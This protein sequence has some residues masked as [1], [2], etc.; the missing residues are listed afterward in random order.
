M[1]VHIHSDDLFSQKFYW[2]NKLSGELPETN[3]MLDYIRPLFSSHQSKSL[4]FDL[5]NDLSQQIINIANN[6]YFS[7]YLIIVSALNILLQRYTRNNDVIVGI[8]VYDQIGI[9]SVNS[10]VIALRNQVK[11]GISFKDLLLE[12]K[13][14]TIAAYTHQNYD[15]DE[16]I[17]I[18]E[19]P[20]SPSRCPIFDIV[21]LLENIHSKNNLEQLKNDITIAFLVDG[22]S[23]SINIEYKENLFKHENIKL[24]SR[25]YT[26]ILDNI[27]KDCNI[28]ISDLL[29]LQKN[30]E[31]QL[32]KDF[33][34]NTQ[35]Y[36]VNQTINQL[37][38]KQV[39]QTPNNIAVIHQETKLTYR[40][41]NQKA[42]QLA[43]L[44]RKLGVAKREFVGIFKDRDINFLI[45]ILAI[46][47]AGGAYVPI[48]ST[49]PPNRI[50]YMLS[51]S[52]VR[53]LLTDYPLLNNLSGLVGDCSQLSSI[54]CLDNVTT[55]NM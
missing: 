17:K 40:E 31:N 36:P 28:K 53:F 16:L 43:R 11:P 32:L 9:N 46:Y 23:I 21:I 2:I 51:N 27:I 24:M 47:K 26:N 29:L 6:S 48:D 20:I 4:R 14:A 49:Y 5:S 15:F 7:I 19:I 30:E 13:E 39:S 1:A 3:L 33:N 38:E 37:F 54:I 34:N 12:V 41:L 22:E 25:C 44:L 52:E 42:N 8:P 35:K 18:L 45:A 55:K 50:Q 10:K